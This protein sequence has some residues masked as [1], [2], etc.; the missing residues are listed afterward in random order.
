LRND[1]VFVWH[2]LHPFSMLYKNNEKRKHFI[3]YT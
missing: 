3:D 2:K 1:G